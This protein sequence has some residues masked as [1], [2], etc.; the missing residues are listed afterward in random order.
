MSFLEYCKKSAK[1]FLD[2]RKIALTSV[3]LA[4][5]VALQAFSVPLVGETMSIQFTFIISAVSG[6]FLGPLLSLVR[7]A[8]S[9][10]IGFLLFPKG[11]FFFGY[12]LSAMLSA[13]FYSIAFWNGKVKFYKIVLAKLAVSLFCNVF[14]GSVWNV[15]L[16]GKKTFIV[17]LG[18]AFFKNLIMFPI[19]IWAISVVFCALA[20][21]KSISKIENVGDL[22]SLSVNSVQLWVLVGATLVFAVLAFVFGKD[23]YSWAKTFVK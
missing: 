1:E 7:G 23:I 5:S 4:M 14:L 22:S 11:A 21:V 6:I 12:T 3:F 8:L 20:R 19:E 18:L 17:Y 16:V 15:V 13:C 9:D 10:I 2:V